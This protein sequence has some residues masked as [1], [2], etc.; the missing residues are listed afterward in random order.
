MK[1]DAAVTKKVAHLARIAVDDAEVE[2]LSAHLSKI[3]TFME[4]LNEL[5][6]D[7]VAP[8]VYMKEGVNVW[9][10]DVVKSDI[11]REEALKNAQSE[12]NMYF[13][14]PKMIEK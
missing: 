4:K 12:N 7:H 2:Q 14:V 11:S 5:D 3:L 10:E 8:L 6:T 13:T 1:I 9:R